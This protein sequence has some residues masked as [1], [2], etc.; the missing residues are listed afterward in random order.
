VQV[1]A[2]TIPLVS[3]GL[4]VNTHAEAVDDA[5]RRVRPRHRP[6]R[7]ARGWVPARSRTSRRPLLPCTD[8]TGRLGTITAW[9]KPPLMST[10]KTALS[11]AAARP[12]VAL[13]VAGVALVAVPAPADAHVEVRPAEVEGGG[14]ANVA[15]G[16][17]NE[18]DNASTTRLRVILPQDQPIRS[19]RVTPISGWRARVDTRK[20][21]T[22]IE[23]NGAEVDTVVSQVTWTAR[24]GG[25][26]PGA[27]ADFR[28][29]LGEL[30]KSG[31]LAFTVLQTYSSGEVARWNEVSADGTGELEHPAPVLS[32]TAPPEQVG[33]EGGTASPEQGSEAPDAAQSDPTDTAAETD[34]AP[35]Q[36]PA[37]DS[38]STLSTVLLVGAVGAATLAVAGALAWRRRR[39]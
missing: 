12:G 19:A 8:A 4:A 23:A 34:T 2:S 7:V 29:R 31:D 36:D 25:I 32:L 26:R 22:P 3:G 5:L 10:M 1:G 13:A 20:L 24:S 11:R 6:G 21:D 35:S 9:E 39:G 37:T 28:L 18:R 15:F 16:V 33:A 38:S 14:F 17:P 27:L 30:P